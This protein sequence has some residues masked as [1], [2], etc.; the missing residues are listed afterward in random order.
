MQAVML[1]GQMHQSFTMIGSIQKSYLSCIYASSNTSRSEISILQGNIRKNRITHGL[2][3]IERHRA[4]RSAGSV[5]HG[6]VRGAEPLVQ[7]TEACAD[8]LITLPARWTT[9]R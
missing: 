7:P 6:D 4:D 8:A 9:K 2:V 5:Q 3:A 1:S